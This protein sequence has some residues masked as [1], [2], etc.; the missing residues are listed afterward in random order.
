VRIPSHRVRR[1]SKHPHHI[2]KRRC[3]LWWDV[4]HTRPSPR[5]VPLNVR[6]PRCVVV[7]PVLRDDVLQHGSL[8]VHVRL[9][10]LNPGNTARNSPPR[11]PMT[12]YTYL[13]ACEI[14]EHRIKSKNL[15]ELTY[16]GRSEQCAPQAQA[17]ASSGR[18]ASA[19]M[20]GV[21]FHV[22]VK[23]QRRPR[24]PV[25]LVLKAQS[26]EALWWA[27]RDSLL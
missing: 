22:H 1:T 17:T 9:H 2:R 25:L 6:L 26:R 3:T 8:T 23:Q 27:G 21:L 14:F 20:D 12:N 16:G 5:C 11:P 24:H 10:P 19:P 15:R 13:S 4:H 7:G 18:T